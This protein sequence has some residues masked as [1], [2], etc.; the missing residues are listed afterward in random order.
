[1]S[2]ICARPRLVAALLAALFVLL[3]AAPGHAQVVRGFTARTNVSLNGDITLIGNTLMSCNGNGQ[4]NNA[5]NGTGNN[6]N[7]NDFNMQYVDVDA[8]GT[9][10]CSSRATLTLAATSTVIWAGL[11]WMGDSNNGARNQV[12]FSTPAAGYVTLTAT[13]LDVS[14]TVYQG[15]IDVTSRV[16][17]GGNGSYTVANVQSTTGTNEFAGWALVVMYRDNTLPPRNL[18]VFDGYAS[19]APGASVAI[20]VSGF[21]TP[22]AGPVNTRLGVVAGEGD[23]GFTGDSFLLNG[24]TISDA[25]NP[26]DNFFNSSISLLGV[27]FT[28]KT[29]NYLNQLGWDVDLVSA[30]GVL[31]NNA[32]GATL[33]LNSTNDQYYPGV[34]TFA[35]DLYQPIIDGNS[36]TKTVVDLNGGNV[37]PGDL[38]EY[39]VAM[40]NTGQDGAT[41]LVMRDTLAANVS[42]VAGSLSVASGANAGAKSDA[43]GDDQMEYDAANR[44]IV[45]RLGTGANA[46][47]GG[48]LAPAA[49][50]SVKF[51]VRVS[52]PAPTGT[53]VSNQAELTFNGQ[54][55]GTPFAT[56]SDGN[57]NVAGNQPTTVSVVAP[58]LTGTVFE[59]VNYGGGAGRSLAAAAGV[60]RPGARAELYDST[61]TYLGS[62]ITD[63]AGLYSFNG[64]AP[65]RYTVRI[66]NGSVTSSRP[67]AVS[68]LVP[69]QTFRADASSGVAAADVNRV[70]GETPT[71]VDAAANTTNQ[72]LAA[73]TTATTTA[74]SVAPV[75]LGSADLGGVDFGFNFDTIVNA[76]DGGQGSLRQFLI[77]S[78]TLG[79]A[80]LAQAGQSAGTEAS[81]FMASDGAAHPG[82]RAGLASTLTGGVLAIVPQSPLPAITDAGTRLDGATQTSDVGNTNPGALGSGGTVGV[83]GVALGTV[84]RPEVEIRDGASLAIG[85]DLQAANGTVRAIAIYGF[86]NAAASNA[87]A[88]LRVGAAATGA[89]IERDVI[90]T[91]ATSFADPGAAL[92][93][94]GDHVRALGG[95]NGVVR[96]NLIAYG[97]GSGI[98]LT[99]GSNGWQ[100]TDDEIRGNAIGSAVRSGVSIE[101]SGAATLTGNLIT[102]HEGDGVDARSSS[103][104]LMLTNNSISQSGLGTAVATPTAGVRLGGSA[105]T[106]DRNQIFDNVGAGVMVAS[107]ASGNVITHNSIWHNGVISNGGGGVPSGQIGIDLQAG[108]DDANHGTS[109]FVTLNDAGDAD[110]GANGL[111]NFPVLESAV[112]A[113]GSFTLTGWARPGSTIEL[114]VADPD[115][116]G[117]GEGKTWVATLVEGSAADLDPSTS[118][119]AG[120]VNGINQGSDNTN[121]F[122]FTI[123]A[124]AGV[125][126]GV[127]L[128]A[129]GTAAQGTSEFSGLVTVTTG[130]AVAGFA[131]ADGNHNA[132]RDAGEAGTGASLWAKLVLESAPGSARQVAAVDPATGAYAFTFVNAGVYDVLIDDNASAGDVTPAVPGGWIGTETASGTWTGLA[133]A[134][135][136]LANVNFGFYHGARIDGAVFRDDGA[137]GAIANDGA[138]QVGESG[139]SGARVQLISGS[140][141]GGECDSALTTGDGTFTLWLPAAAAGAV[142]V[143]EPARFGA[144]ATG[145]GAGNT[146]G[147]Y[148][149]ASA[150]VSFNAVSGT[151]YSGLAFGEVPLNTLAPNGAQSVAPGGAA[152]YAHRFTAGSAG[153]VAFSIVQSSAPSLPGWSTALYQDTNCDGVVNPGEPLLSGTPSLTAGQTLCLVVKQDAPAGAPPGAQGTATL[154][155]S[156]TYTGAAPPLSSSASASD[157]TTV[158]VAGAGLVI[159]KSVSL[160]S[161]RPG[162]LLTYTI[163]YSNNGAAP[164]S[165]IVIRDA[166]PAFTVFESGACGTLGTGLTGCNLSSQPAFGTTGPVIWTLTGSLAPGGSGSVSY[167]VRLP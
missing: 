125:A 123:A 90:G 53:V 113:N 21:V 2:R 57:A 99:A 70:G 17:S 51:R 148:S 140:C 79:N 107:G 85:V 98:A 151:S 101:S 139:I 32:T 61:G 164:I 15:F 103:G 76:N 4:C 73:L 48:S 43:A 152:F 67:G 143:R 88:D 23:L 14:G 83:D 46:V 92:R 36:F 155:A 5:R 159:V 142:A 75:T 58:N 160:A 71:L 128:T 19:V 64:W 1:M 68:T 138:K 89:L 3:G 8:D 112:L 116:T 66:V 25:N 41:N 40:S 131:Y 118:S 10:F 81:I 69:L 114:F 38:L 129:T 39:T 158:S 18:V 59:D 96:D 144:L 109:P 165:S 108:A 126:G 16:Q 130:V 147:S 31:A 133:V 20:P 33:T 132:A 167:Q 42:Y 54:Q 22:P 65:G 161:A 80:G 97:A 120:L 135:A 150:T 121:R 91:P 166:T 11:Y 104:A 157:L 111:F 100:I 86:G 30:N 26:G 35:T 77:N 84:A 49:A 163:A 105:S 117:F 72:N 45:A 55:L 7:N 137:G 63:G 82:L 153:S 110:A 127:A 156:F 149:R 62:A 93:S 134:G 74:Q 154:S 9:T 122:R 13:Q 119:Y 106:L 141:A 87:D 145:G 28:N 146:S 27:T 136:D 34:V 37:A 12:R 124:P 94:G 52:P 115:P 95:A 60:A 78:A 44:R 6:V 24:T 56:R 102:G 47:S 29:P 50:T 162:D